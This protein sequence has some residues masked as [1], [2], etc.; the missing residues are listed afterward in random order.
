MALQLL[1]TKTEMPRPHSYLVARRRLLERLDN[2]LAA[3]SSLLFVSAPAGYGKTTLLVDWVLHLLDLPRPLGFTEIRPVWLTL[4]EGDNDPSRFLR[5]LAAGLQKVDDALG[6]RLLDAIPLTSV[7]VWND[8]L[9]VCVNALAEFAAHVL[10]VLDDY[11]AVQSEAVHAIVGWLLEYGPPNLHLVIATRV[12]PP[13]PLARLRGRGRVA[14]LRHLD[15]CFD[16]GEAHMF[17]VE[18]MGLPLAASQCATLHERTEGWIAGLQ[19]AA[20]CL[21][22]RSS[23]AEI[24]AFLA[25][26]AG[27]NRQIMDYLME[28]VYQRQSAEVRRFLLRTSILERFDAP[29]CSVMLAGEALGAADVPR[30][31]VAET[32]CATAEAQLVLERLEHANLFLVPLDDERKLYRYHHLF[33]VLLRQRLALEQPGALAVLHLRASLWYEQQQNLREAIQHALAARCFDRAAELIERAA[34]A[35]MMVSEVAT[36]GL[37]VESLPPAILQAHPLLCL[38]DAGALLLAGQRTELAE[39]R[40]RDGLSN[41]DHA[42]LGGQMAVYQALSAMLQG[43]NAQS[44]MLAQ[45]SL[46]LLPERSPFF[47]SMASLILACDILLTGDDELAAQRL[48]EALSLSDEVGNMMNSVL[49]RTHLAELAILHNRLAEAEIL[50]REAL[51]I[52]TRSGEPEPVRG[53]PLMGYGVLAY[54][55][56]ELASAQRMLE[57]GIEAVRGWGQMGTVQAHI[58]LFKVRRALGDEVGAAAM[59]SAADEL[60]ARSRPPAAMLGSHVQF[61]HMQAALRAGDLVTADHYAELAGLTAPG[62][63]ADLVIPVPLEK[64][65]VH[66][67]RAQWLRGHGRGR[68]ALTDLDILLQVAVRQERGRLELQVRLEQSL[69]YFALD[70]HERALVVLDSALDLARS[71]G[72][73]RLVIDAGPPMAELLRA[74]LHHGVHTALTECLLAALANDGSRDHAV[75]AVEGNLPPANS[76]SQ[77]SVYPLSPCELKVL[78]MVAQGMTNGEI[79]AQLMVALSTVKTHIN[80]ICRKLDVPNRTSAVAKARR[81]GWLSDR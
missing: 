62:P 53:V 46:E 2:G 37:W 29:L 79:A 27:N 72:A 42:G 50:Y 49:A 69:I 48:H 15:L 35:T 73:L 51:A 9:A 54:E 59:L 52:A 57:E 56:N 13:L 30:S 43:R 23:Q 5:Y 19:M 10:L 75:R 34:E 40:L 36:L 47:R 11:H 26:F 65:Y 80:H 8:V 74:A 39:A 68:E 28:E 45:R 67:A 60:A 31:E 44:I 1:A 41:G 66:L 38:Y 21:Q 4:D 55:R 16:A 18:A 64:C 77:R 81:L 71:A 33:A 14:E 63:A 7:P 58:V 6:A 32:A 70:Q 61:F 25:A 20:V 78:E 12:D 24:D 3:G 22:G 76:A 17:L